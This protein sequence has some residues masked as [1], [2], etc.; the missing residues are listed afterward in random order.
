MAATDLLDRSSVCLSGCGG[1][2]RDEVELEEH[3]DLGT[4]AFGRA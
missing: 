4:M 2:V 1:S 3:G